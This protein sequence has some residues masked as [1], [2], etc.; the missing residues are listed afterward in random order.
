MRMKS[1]VSKVACLVVAL[2]IYNCLCRP[3]TNNSPL[4]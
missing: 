1:K 2:E 3:R 4:M